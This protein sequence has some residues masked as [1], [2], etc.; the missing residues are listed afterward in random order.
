MIDKR[1]EDSVK[2]IIRSLCALKKRQHVDI[3]KYIIDNEGKTVTDIYIHFRIEQSRASQVL[4][5]LRF[6][7]MVYQKR[8]GQFMLYYPDQERISK[9]E[10]F[11]NGLNDYAPTVAS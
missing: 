4:R 2:I 6:S 10:N 5:D 7:G 1:F 8:E 9:I 11:I 3:L